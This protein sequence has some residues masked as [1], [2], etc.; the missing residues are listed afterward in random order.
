MDSSPRKGSQ[1]L[2]RSEQVGREEGVFEAESPHEGL[3]GPLG[4]NKEAL[5]KWWQARLAG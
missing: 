3:G 5:R 2:D 4:G 1:R